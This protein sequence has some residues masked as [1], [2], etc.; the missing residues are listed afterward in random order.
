MAY[1]I[2]HDL[3][4]LTYDYKVK[5]KN[6][7]DYLAMR[8]KAESLLSSNSTVEAIDLPSRRDVLLG[9]GKATL[10]YCAAL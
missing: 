2:P 1:G 7:L 3:I 8:K 4:P 10:N 9:K 6:H 5:T